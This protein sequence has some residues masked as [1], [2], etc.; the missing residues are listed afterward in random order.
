MISDPRVASEFGVGPRA[1]APMPRAGIRPFYWS[2]RRELWEHTAIHV[3]PLVTA[4]VA[5]LAFAVSAIDLPRARRAMLLLDP[6]QQRTRITWPYDI[7]F[8]AIMFSVFL[9]WLFYCLD[10]LHGERRDRS[11]LFWK[12]LPVSDL[13]AV[14][15]KASVPLVLL[16]A[17]AFVLVIATQIVMLGLSDVVLLANGLPLA[18]SS[19]LPL[20]QSWPTVLIG[21]LAMTLWN[22][23]M[24]GWFLLV[25]AW[26]R[27]ATLL[28][29]VLP[30][31]VLGILERIAF[32][33]HVFDA[34][35]RYRGMA[36]TPTPDAFPPRRVFMFVPFNPLP[37]AQLLRDP[38][39]WIGL[40]FAAVLFVAAARVRRH[41][42]PL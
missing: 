32:H 13:T 36:W 27:R 33:T 20:F 22:A 31:I 5:L 37:P 1:D 15:A 14:M 25:S 9:V 8:N 24:Y 38:A 26:A 16:P 17:F 19:Q 6:L 23:P 40:L 28:W 42:G 39:L 12:S 34:W 35:T 2:V 30:P 7:A 18:T 11:V 3:A 41:R 4:G 21:L 29:G 10:A